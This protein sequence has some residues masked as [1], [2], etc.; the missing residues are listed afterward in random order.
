[1]SEAP[2][3]PESNDPFASS[4][5]SFEDAF[6]GAD[7]PPWDDENRDPMT[8]GPMTEGMSASFALDMARVWVQQHQKAT[9][10]GAFAVGAF[11]GALLRDS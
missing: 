1:M 5:P 11:V 6:E 4:S 8:E 2:P 9:M 10:L 3:N 7:T